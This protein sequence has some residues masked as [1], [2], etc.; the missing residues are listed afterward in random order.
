MASILVKIA[1]DYRQF[2]N[3]DGTIVVQLDKALYG[4]VEA[5]S[6]WYN[7]LKGKLEQYGLVANPYDTCVFNKTGDDGIQTTVVLHVDD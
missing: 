6:L 5:A 1:P 3:N 7:E 2:I 4:T